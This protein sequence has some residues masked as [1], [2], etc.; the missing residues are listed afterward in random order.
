MNS[1]E[2]INGKEIAQQNIALGRHHIVQ[3][4][5]ELRSVLATNLL[6]FAVQWLNRL[7]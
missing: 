1:G 7:Q 5:S 6:M 3:Q 2:Q 4:V